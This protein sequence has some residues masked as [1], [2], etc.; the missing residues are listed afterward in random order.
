S[1][2]AV[3]GHFDGVSAI[4]YGLADKSIFMPL[5]A[6]YDRYG[7]NAGWAAGLVINYAGPYQGSTWLFSGIRNPNF[8]RTSLFTHTLLAA[9]KRMQ[10]GDLA[11]TAQHLRRRAQSTTPKL[12]TAAPPANF[13]ISADHRQFIDAMGKPFV[14]N[15]CNYLGCENRFCQLDLSKLETDFARARDAGVNAFRIWIGGSDPDPVHRDAIRQC[16]RKYGI[17]LIFQ[18]GDYRTDGDAVVAKTREVAQNWKDEPMVLG[19]DLGNEPQLGIIAPMQ[20]GGKRSPLLELHPYQH[21]KS[22]IDLNWVEQMVKQRPAWPQIIGSPSQA[23]LRD[24]YAAYW[25]FDRWSAAF[26]ANGSDV[27]TFPGIKG[28]LP[29]DGEWQDFAVALNETFARWIHYVGGALH[30]ADPHHFISVGYNTVLSCL[31]C[32]EAL[33]FVSQHIYQAPDQFSD[34]MANLTTMDR[35]A[36]A[37][38]DKPI[39]LGEFGYSNGLQI[40][41]RSLDIYTSAL[42]EAIHYLYSLAHGHSGCLKWMLID[43]PIP[44]LKDN[45][46][47][48][49][50]SSRLYEGRFG[51]YWCDGT[52]VGRLKPIGHALRFIR[53]FQQSGKPP[54]KLQILPG[55]TLIGAVYRFQSPDALFIGDMR[56][57][58]AGLDFHTLNGLPTNVMLMRSGRRIKLMATADTRLSIDP[59]QLELARGLS[60]KRVMGR[61]GSWRPIGHRIQIELLEGE[62]VYL[63]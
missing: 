13:R 43:L 51:I 29:L 56:F 61:C 8:Y 11:I 57:A 53:E 10:A 4:G 9:L 62:A 25:I 47:W 41:G 35:L 22:K 17:A 6:A 37:W 38:P 32:N 2:G 26:T 5:L 60:L 52:P 55:S 14:L 50:P 33:D 20:F 7:R 63:V 58:T 54:E 19:Y 12:T 18:L 59:S 21:Y 30:Q 3:E 34:V 44:I 46:G 42:G 15:G 39:T 24:I 23:D 31:P 49:A 48:I 36:Q 1:I 40:G 16:A 45:V 28:T 27:T